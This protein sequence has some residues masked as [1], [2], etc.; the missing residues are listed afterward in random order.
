MKKMALGTGALLAAPYGLRSNITNHTS[1]KEYIGLALIGAGGMGT[2]DAHTALSVGGVK[3]IA[4]CDLYDARIRKAVDTWGDNIYT[5]K[6]YKEILANPN[7][8]AVIVATPDHWHQKISVDALRAGKHVYCEKPVIHRVKEGQDLIKAGRNH[9]NLVF[10]TGSQGMSSVGNIIARHL[11]QNGVLGKVNFI[12]GQFSAAPNDPAWYP[13]PDDATEKT[14][15]WERFIGDS[16]KEGFKPQRFFYWRNWKEYSTGI[17]GDLFVHVI[18]SVHYI[19][20]T[21]GPTKVYTTGG[22]KHYTAGYQNVPDV[23]LAYID[24]PDKRNLGGFT[25]SVGANYVD[26][27]SNKWG[28]TN[29]R[30]VGEKGAMNVLWDRVELKTTR[31]TDTSIFSSLDSIK[32][33]INNPQKISEK[34]YI[35]KANPADRGGHYNHFFNFFDCIKN[36]KQPIGDAVFGVQ[37]AAVALLCF[38]SYEQNGPV[39]WDASN[40]KVL[41]L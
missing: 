3:L 31:E 14:I 11:I 24:Y 38:D 36:K 27:V 40:L 28:S 10:Q 7:V 35:I 15:W 1:K 19:M 6:D 37:T 20:D 2:A 34:E 9:R 23:M 25:L 16:S 29:F 4:V 18:A 8:D 33:L 39:Y 26:G 30:I 12:D 13:I 32:H 22:L 17:A 41:K 5:T 21:T